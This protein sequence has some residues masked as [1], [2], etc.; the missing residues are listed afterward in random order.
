MPFAK[1]ASLVYAIDV[2]FNQL[3]YKLRIDPRVRVFEKTNIFD[4]NQ[5][6]M[7]PNLAV[8]DVSFRSAIS[9]C[10]D[11]INKISDGFIITLI[12]PQF[13]L[14]G[15]DLDIKDFSGVVETRYLAKILDKVI[16]KFYDNKLQVKNILE[17][18]IKGRKGNQEFMFLVTKD[19]MFELEQALALLNNLNY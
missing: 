19:S 7:C 10:V 5:F 9:I 2:G 15:L 8:I 13:E 12:K 14:K 18:K 17:L 3:S 11:L 6:D 16:R 1:G 4:I